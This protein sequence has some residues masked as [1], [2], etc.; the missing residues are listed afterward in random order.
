MACVSAVA[1][2]SQFAARTPNLLSEKVRRT[3]NDDTAVVP[4]RCSGPYRLRHGA[5]HC[6]DVGRVHPG[7]CNLDDDIS[8][9]ARKSERSDWQTEAAGSSGP[10]DAQRIG[11][12]AFRGER[13]NV[14][15]R[16]LSWWK[17]LSSG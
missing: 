4:P 13:G 6:L 8:A 11:G 14:H 15:N 17:S 7:G 12:D 16:V 5:E 3:V 9:R 10:G 1:A 2:D